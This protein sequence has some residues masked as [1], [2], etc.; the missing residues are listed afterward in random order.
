MKSGNLGELCLKPIDVLRQ[1][2]FS[3]LIPETLRQSYN[4][5]FLGA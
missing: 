2:L 5:Y 3:T 1:T 4:A